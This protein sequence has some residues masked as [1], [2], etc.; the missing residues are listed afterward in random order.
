MP[1]PRLLPDGAVGGVPTLVQNIPANVDA[2]FGLITR[3]N[4][5]VTLDP[6]IQCDSI[7]VV[8][9]MYG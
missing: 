7:F 5:A 9:R 3:G 6:F 1:Q 8:P 4:S 2:P